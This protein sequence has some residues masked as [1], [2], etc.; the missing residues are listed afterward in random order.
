LEP[1]RLQD[2]ATRLAAELL[3]DGEVMI[4]GAAGLEDAGPGDITFVAR[5]GLA[6]RLAAS[7]AAAVIVGPAMAPDRPAL[8]VA[9]PYR[10]FAALLAGLATPLDRIFPPG[11]HP[12]ATVD[13]TA[14][15]G[16]GVS[17]A[18]GAVVG[19]GCRLGDRVRLGPGVVLEPDVTIGDDSVLYANVV[20]RERC[21]LGRRVILHP[22]CVV[23]AD[24]FGYLPGP[25]GMVKIPQVGIVILEDD[26]E[27]GACTCVDRATTG[28][29]RI[30]AGTK[31]DNLVQVAHNVQIGRH[32]VFSAQTG[33]SGSCRIGDG[34][35]MGG[36][37]GLADHLTVGDGAK[38]GAKSGLHRDVPDGKAMFGYP[39]LE[40]AEA[41]RVAAALKRLPELLKTVARLEQQ[42]AALADGKET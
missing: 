30:G 9:D 23:G 42:L 8:R 2:L 13:G 22:G 36:Q 38:I 21:R 15:V 3:G 33:I 40:A 20:I 10:T 1:V 39:A 16:R 27:L 31:L 7:R 35:F 41:M 28:V 29:T 37:V 32:S 12:A 26:V 11:V 19:A 4:S 18:P 34:V 17:V 14:S 5:P 24:G 25:D 6:E